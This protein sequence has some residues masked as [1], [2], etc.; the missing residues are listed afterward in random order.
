MAQQP[1]AWAQ[2]C[3]GAAQ[4]P[5]TPHWALAHK[6]RKG[7]YCPMLHLG[8]LAG[9]GYKDWWSSPNF[10]STLLP[11]GDDTL[12]LCSGE[13]TQDQ[14]IA[15]LSSSVAMVFLLASRS[16]H[17]GHLFIAVELCHGVVW[18]SLGPLPRWVPG[19]TTRWAPGTTRLAL[20]G[21]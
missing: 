7:M 13:C 19:P 2:V 15:K 18:T 17:Q 11:P 12:A 5:P 10:A 14:G 16:M 1:P 8:F 21:T 20:H 4:W 3:P 6:V 9:R